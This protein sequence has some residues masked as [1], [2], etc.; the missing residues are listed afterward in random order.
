MT[1]IAPI[2][3][4]D[5]RKDELWRTL[6]TG[7][8]GDLFTS[9]PW[10][11]AV[12]STYGFT[13]AARIA[14]D[15]DGTPRGGLAW[16]PVSDLRGDRLC[17]LPFS[18]WADPVAP[19]TATWNALVDGLIEPGTSLTLRC[20]HAA[21]P[22]ADPRLRITGETVQHTTRIDAPIEDIHRRIDQA[23]RRNIA[24]AE[25]GG[26]RVEAISGIRG[27]QQFH[28][29]QVGLRKRKYRMLAQPVEFFENIWDRFSADCSVVTMLARHAEDTVAGV[30]FLAW[31]GIL[32][33][34]FAASRP[35]YLAMRPNDAVYWAGIRWAAERGMRAVDWGASDV[36][37]PGLIRFKSKYATDE[38]RI[39][40]LKSAGEPSPAQAEAGRVLGDITR[41]F[42]DESVPDRITDEA[43]ALLYR[44]FC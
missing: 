42:T 29:L 39:V 13:P 16:V 19:D 15:A 38:K 10:I 2:T 28:Q 14:L 35:D 33:C 1:T 41:L 5:P 36:D 20:L 9:P 37:Q 18:D 30:V 8:H 12:C 44:Y 11:D 6:A 22:V 7:E 26:I 25:R 34:K 40:A 24:K 23:A 3:T 32:H 27:V 21:E 43:G 17:S 4:V 31:N